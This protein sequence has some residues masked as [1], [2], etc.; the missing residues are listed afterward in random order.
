MSPIP[1]IL[2]IDDDVELTELLTDYL[3]VEGF[4]VIVAHDG[5]SGLE[6]AL[7]GEAALI[8][9]DV[10]L[11]RMNGL[12]VLRKLRAQA[13]VPVLML[14]ARGEDIDRIVG[15]EIGADDYLSKPFNAR[16]LSRD[17][18]MELA[19][20]REYEAFDRS[21]DVHISNVRKKLATP[22]EDSG[23]IKTIRGTG[24]LYAVDA[25]NPTPL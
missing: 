4:E 25:D 24:Y 6:R 10:M 15:L 20:G 3:K 12:D 7:S 1:T 13:E 21:L 16:A 11:P 17:K 14:T 18:L 2:L 5:P 8:I 22:H 9:L 19:R 23:R